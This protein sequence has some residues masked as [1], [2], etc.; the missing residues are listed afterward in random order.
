MNTWLPSARA[1]KNRYGTSAGASAA[2]ILASPGLAMGPGGRPGYRYVLYR[3]STSRSLYS[4]RPTCCGSA[5]CTVGSACNNMRFFTRFQYTAL[6]S[7]RSSALRASFST[8]L[9]MVMAS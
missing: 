8:M 1:T 3:D 5:Y 2:A 9:A 6:M 7:G 4:T